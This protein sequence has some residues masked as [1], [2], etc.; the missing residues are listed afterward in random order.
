MQ[1]PA[2]FHVLMDYLDATGAA[3]MDI[4]RFLDRWHRLRSHEAFPCP[5]CFLAGEERPLAPLP[6]RGKFELVK[7]P[8]CRTQFNIP[9]DE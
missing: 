9:I 1:N 8:T 6:A 5:A 4:E 3:P 2:L 7:C